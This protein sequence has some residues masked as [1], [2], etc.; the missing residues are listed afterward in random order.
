[1]LLVITQI[2][3]DLKNIKNLTLSL[4]FLDLKTYFL[5]FLALKITI[6]ASTFT[7]I[8]KVTAFFPQIFCRPFFIFFLI[9]LK[10]PLTS[11]IFLL[12]TSNTWFFRPNTCFFYFLVLKTGFLS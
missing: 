11:I 7:K 2:F 12:F 8:S 1:M 5:A 10:R 9:C 6:L 3:L 4:A